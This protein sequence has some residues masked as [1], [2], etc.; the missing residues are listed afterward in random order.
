MKIIRSLPLLLTFLSAVSADVEFTVPPAGST[1][2]AGDVITVHWKESGNHPTISELAQYDLYLC[3]GGDTP[4][5]YD[6]AE[7]L[8]KNGVFE[9]GNSV[10]FRISP[11]VGGDDANAYFLKMVSS[12]PGTSIINFSDRFTI[13]DTTGS[14][15]DK[16]KENVLS[17]SDPSGQ[18]I[19]AHHEREELRKRQNIGAYTI[20]YDQQSG[21][22]RYAPMA[23]RPG[24]AITATV[25]APQYPTS[26]YAL[27]TT[28]LAEAT[29]KTTLSA[30]ATYSVSSVEN[31]APAASQATVD[32]KMKRFLE[33]WKD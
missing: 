28:Y 17:I 16:I 6:E 32:S 3:A 8:I 11:S 14:F 31:T 30:T 5:S 27:A 19:R 24:T 9:R 23:K 4:D 1:I 26:A 2:K 22:T 7:L 18:M 12:G 21:L 13:S 10:S 20:P 33:R 25:T 15:S 29:I